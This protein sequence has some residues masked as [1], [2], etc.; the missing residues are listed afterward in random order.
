MEEDMKK[1]KYQKPTS[2]DLYGKFAHG[3]ACKSGSVATGNCTVG[4]AVSGSGQC[5][6]GVDA[7]N[8]CNSGTRAG[9]QCVTGGVVT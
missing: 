1:N 4:T 8:H 6:V 3:E 7:E 5:T 9:G 2:V